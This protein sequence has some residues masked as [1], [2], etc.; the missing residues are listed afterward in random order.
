MS[1]KVV[2]VAVVAV[3]VLVVLAR[4]AA[5]ARARGPLTGTRLSVTASVRSNIT[6]AAIE[7]A[8]SG[9]RQLAPMPG[10]SGMTGIR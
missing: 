1:R 6:K 2:I 7:N 10:T 8:M 4:R 9:G 5:A 3:V